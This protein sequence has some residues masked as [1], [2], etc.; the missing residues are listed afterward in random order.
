MGCAFLALRVAERGPGLVDTV[1][2]ADR[3]GRVDG[4][5]PG[6]LAD[7]ARVAARY[8]PLVPEHHHS[9]RSADGRTHLEAWSAMDEAA[10]GGYFAQD[11]GDA[12]AYNGWLQEDEGWPLACSVAR[13]LLSAAAR[14]DLRAALDQRCGEYA[15]LQACAD[16]S[17]RAGTDFLGAQHLYY[18]QRGGLL[19][20]SNRAFLVAAALD[21]GG[22][23]PIEAMHLSWLMSGLRAMFAGETLFADVR[24]LGGGHTLAADDRGL[25]LTGPTADAELATSADWDVHF[26]ELCERVATIRRLPGLPFRQTLTGGKDSRLLLGALVASGAIEDLQDCF[27]EAEPGHPDAE[28]AEH[29]GAHY[30]LQVDVFPAE[31]TH[32][33]FFELIQQ[34]NF[35]TEIAFHAYDTKGCVLRPRRGV[36]NGFHGEIFKSHLQPL[37]L[38]GWSQVRARYAARAF[39]DQWGLLTEGAIAHCRTRLLQEAERWQREGTP[40]A[41]V[42]DRWH[43]E[44]RMHRWVGQALQFEATAELSFNPLASP[45]LLRRYQQLPLH[46]RKLQR[47]HLELTRRVDDWLWRQPFANDRWSRL[48]TLGQRGLGKPV[49]ADYFGIQT[50]FR[51]WQQ[52][53]GEIAAFLLDG[54]DDG[55]FDIID[56]RGLEARLALARARPSKRPVEQMLGCVGMRAALQGI[57]VRPLR[58]AAMV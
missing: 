20:I 24:I 28:V 48:L 54:Q 52:A 33:P 31:H 2:P 29:L 25:R 30:G 42:H 49:K 43:R 41:D 21:G 36:I 53:E 46:D 7:R 50:Q 16:G 11:A 19:A 10:R 3:V 37:F 32:E 27:V 55:F 26:A 18:G 57:E 45:H 8:L 51:H 40:L 22:L 58:I 4:V 1:D 39:I 13:N 23:P 44:C 6:N 17:L 35:Q 15:V 56:R 47:V 38:L 12:L 9:W 14:T 5:G 34:H